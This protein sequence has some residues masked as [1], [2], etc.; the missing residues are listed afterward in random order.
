[1]NQRTIID[2]LVHT[3]DQFD[4]SIGRTLQL[5]D[6]EADIDYF[7]I[8]LYGKLLADFAHRVLPDEKQPLEQR[9][10]VLAVF[11]AS[12]IAEHGGR[13]LCASLDIKTML[14]L[15]DEIAKRMRL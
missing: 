10:M 3:V 12:E 2:L 13:D 14:S 9:L 6:S 8:S 15:G 1:M 5:L 11:V 7:L 4:R